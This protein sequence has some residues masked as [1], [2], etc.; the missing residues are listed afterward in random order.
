MKDLKTSKEKLRELRFSEEDDMDVERICALDVELINLINDY[1]AQ[2]IDNMDEDDLK[3][4]PLE[5][6][7]S[8][9]LKEKEVP[10]SIEK[11]R[12][13]G[14]IDAGGANKYQYCSGLM[15]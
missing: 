14:S 3:K 8:V 15:F 2:T 5:Y 12:D 7:E 6:Q 9:I 10:S 1:Q 4:A 13:A 11:T